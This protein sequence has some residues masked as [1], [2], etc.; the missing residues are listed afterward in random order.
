MAQLWFKYR[1]SSYKTC[2]Y[3]YIAGIFLNT[4]ILSLFISSFCFVQEFWC[5]YW[6]AQK[7]LVFSYFQALEKILQK[8][9]ICWNFEVFLSI[10]E[11]HDPGLFQTCCFLLEFSMIL[12][13]RGNSKRYQK[14]ILKI[15]CLMY[16]LVYYLMIIWHWSPENQSDV[17]FNGIIQLMGSQYMSHIINKIIIIIKV[18]VGHFGIFDLQS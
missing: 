10:G 11:G 8:S 1:L 3:H 15:Q 13:L 4:G 6:L 9:L 12:R 5:V 18:T 17:F 14:S 2:F 7:T 16:S